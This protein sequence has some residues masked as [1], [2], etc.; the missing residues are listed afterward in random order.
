MMEAVEA[1][2]RRL[3][4]DYIDLYQIH[5]PDPLT[6]IAE[7]LR[8]LDD[9][10]SQGKVRYVGEC[11]FAG[12]QIVDACWTARAEHLVPLISAQHEYSLLSRD[13]QREVL[14]AASAM[15]MGVL[16]FFPLASGFLT[17]KYRR[18][19]PLPEGAR[20]TNTPPERS[21]RWLNDRNFEQLAKLESFA[22]ERGHTLTELAFAWLLAQ[23]EVASVIAGATR[24][25]QVDENVAAGNWKLSPE[26]FEAVPGL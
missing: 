9:L 17:G 19:E 22:T 7:T 1:S 5:F 10:V 21:R 3:N 4:T 14:P 25:E 26:D 12:W 20:L 16:P 13:A 24:R 8:G 18:G 23:P 11:N 6:P 2:L 15:G